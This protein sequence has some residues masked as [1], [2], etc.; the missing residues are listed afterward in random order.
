LAIIKSG[1]FQ[2]SITITRQLHGSLISGV[3]GF[4]D[5]IDLLFIHDN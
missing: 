3:K 2:S 5:L 1:V 4:K